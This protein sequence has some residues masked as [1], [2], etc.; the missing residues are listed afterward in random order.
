MYFSLTG[1]EKDGP[2]DICAI[3]ADSSRS[4]ERLL[5]HTDDESMKVTR[6]RCL[7]Y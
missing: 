7:E 4:S 2:S 3:E 5:I 6:G 1:T